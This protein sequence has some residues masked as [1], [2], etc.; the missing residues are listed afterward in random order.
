MAKPLIVTGPPRCGTTVLTNILNRHPGIALT[1]ENDLALVAK[2]IYSAFD[3]AIEHESYISSIPSD[4]SSSG[5]YAELARA[6]TDG[7]IDCPEPNAPANTIFEK[8]C[9]VVESFYGAMTGKTGFTWYG[10]KMP[11]VQKKVDIAS[12]EAIGLAPAYI[13]IFRDPIAMVASSNRRWKDTLDGR[14]KWDIS[15]S[16]EAVAIWVEC[17]KSCQALMASGRRVFALK[18]EDLVAEPEKWLKSMFEFLGVD[19][20]AMSFTLLETPQALKSEYLTDTDRALVE[21]SLGNLRK[22]W[23][24]EIAL[25]LAENLSINYVARAGV[26][27]D[28]ARLNP[29]EEFIIGEG[30]HGSD[31][32]CRWTRREGRIKFSLSATDRP[33]AVEFDCVAFV[34]DTQKSGAITVRINGSP[35][36]QLDPVDLHG[37]RNGARFTLFLPDSEDEIVI[38]LENGRFKT[39]TDVPFEEWREL[40]VAVRSLAFK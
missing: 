11:R 4:E 32:W 26:N 40:G 8:Y 23:G 38:S 27:L 16:F 22:R 7:F 28:F 20:K 9:K 19:Q 13:F 33:K 1:L 25:L 29:L 14:D 2:S 30:F 15:S 3:K 31:D 34:S 17:W 6:R 24:E 5:K 12:I 21:G 10:D 18:Y 37:D 35:V 36:L 39:P